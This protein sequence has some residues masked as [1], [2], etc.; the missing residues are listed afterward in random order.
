ME[1]DFIIGGAPKCATTAIFDYLAQHPQIFASDPK[2]PHFYASAALDR[3]VMQ[4]DYSKAEYLDLFEGKRADQVSGEASTHYLHLAE[5]VAPF[6]AQHNPDTRLIFCLR[7]PADRAWS[8]FLY[9]YSTAGPYTLGGMGQQKDFATFLNDPEMFAMGDYVRHLETFERYF[10]ENQILVMYFE[11]I[12]QDTQSS[13]EKICAHIGV[14]TA[15]N[16]D[17]NERSNETAYPR[18]PA[19]MP[20]ADALFLQFYNRAPLHRRKTLLEQRLR[21]LFSSEGRKERIS[22]EQRKLAIDLYRPSIERL[23]DKTG[24]DLTRWLRIAS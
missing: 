1:P 4:G 19:I 16:F 7:D 11:D 6:L 24:A 14:D 8:H 5:S 2:E 13:L 18:V 9:R 3:K 20:V 17:L 12:V 10:N 15:F 23:A 21:L 22:T